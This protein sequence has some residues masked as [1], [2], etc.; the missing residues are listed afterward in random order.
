MVAMSGTLSR[1]ERLLRRAENYDDWFSVAQ[2]HDIH[3]GAASWR[4]EPASK[5][6]DY[7]NI[8]AR[9]DEL[10]SLRAEKDDV[11]LLFALN[12]GIHGNQ[13]G[14]GKA[15]LYEKS[16]IGTKQL[17]SDYVDEIVDA[18]NHIH[19][20]D[21]CAAISKQDKVD[22]FHRAHLCFGRSALML[23]GAGSLGHFHHGVVRTLFTHDLLPK[24]IS[25]SSAGSIFAAILGH[26]MIQNCKRCSLQTD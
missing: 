21:A 15:E 26:M 19:T 13:G 4:A 8:Q 14:M 17:I 6:Y 2:E 23:S 5:F 24:V 7:Q 3:S 11:G 1:L 12:E 22:F 20:S 9:L 25:G 10:R 16:S 18:L